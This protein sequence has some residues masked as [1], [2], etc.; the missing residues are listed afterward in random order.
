MVNKN[1]AGPRVAAKRAVSDVK[2]WKTSST[3]EP[4]EEDPRL[5]GQG[6]LFALRPEARE[7]VYRGRVVLPLAV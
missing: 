1:L 2:N 4:Y 6:N 7:V 3:D 5:S